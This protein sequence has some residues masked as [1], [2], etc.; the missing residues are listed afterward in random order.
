MK[1]IDTIKQLSGT[2]HLVAKDKQGAEVWRVAEKNLIV[3][4]GYT[5]IAE[6]LAGLPNRHIAKIA[7]GTN[8]AAPAE[9]DTEI[10]SAVVL[11]IES[12]EYP[13]PGTVRFNFT[14][15]YDDAVD[16]SI[17]E[18]GLICADGRLF[19]RKTREVIE[20]T[21]YVS[22]TGMWEITM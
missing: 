13:A 8:G 19:S 17:R 10:T 12:V 14:I 20:K 4:G 6:A 11:D 21:S 9:A 5:A 15:G 16:M 7:V 1:C 18:F 2:L 3:A 22:I